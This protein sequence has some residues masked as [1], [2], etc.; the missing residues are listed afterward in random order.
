MASPY[1]TTATIVRQALLKIDSGLDDSEINIFIAMA[2]S[3]VEAI[4]GTQAWR[5]SFNAEKWGIIRRLSTN[6]A[7]IMCMAY[8]VTE[9]TTTSQ[10]TLTADIIWAQI[11][12]DMTILK[13]VDVVKYL[14]SAS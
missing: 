9:F 8:D 14:K 4:T 13:S 6:M 11:E 10:A 3:T 5:T 12:L 7:A 2:E 1:Y